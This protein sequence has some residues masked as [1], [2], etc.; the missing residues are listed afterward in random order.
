[1]EF[2]PIESQEELDQLLTERENAV[3]AEYSD[4]ENLRTTN[5]QQAETI[6]SYER[7]DLRRQ[8]AEETGLPQ[9]LASRINGDDEESMRKDA[10]TLMQDFQNQNRV[11]LPHYDPEPKLG[12][13]NALR[14]LLANMN[15]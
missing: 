9:R 11:V 6:R 1:M 8:I 5:A 12:G 14:Q 15:F 10:Q 3:R 2:T 7:A 13:K 4:Y